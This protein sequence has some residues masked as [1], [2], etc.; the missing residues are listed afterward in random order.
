MPNDNSLSVE[1]LEDLCGKHIV[2]LFRKIHREPQ[3]YRDAMLRSL[4]RPQLP[5][6]DTLAAIRGHELADDAW[7]ETLN[8]CRRSAAAAPWH[9]LPQ[10][11]IKADVVAAHDWLRAQ[12]EGLGPV[13]GIYLG[14]DTLNMEA[15]HG[16][17]VEIGGTTQCDPLKDSSEW[18]WTELR[19]GDDHL[20]RGLFDMHQEFSCEQWRTRDETIAQGSAFSFADYILFLAYSGIVLGHAFKRLPISRTVLPVWGFHDGDLFLLGRKSP[21]SF[22][23]LCK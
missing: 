8:I 15:G 3:A 4:N 13:T 9:K 17:N 19:Y 20:I 11:N 10:P 18:V 14:L 2:E 1:Q 16:K 22:T 5:I 6:E 21:D 7:S 23:F 12:L